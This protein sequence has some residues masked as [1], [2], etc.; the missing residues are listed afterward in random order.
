MS[1]T[2]PTAEALA[3]AL[4]PVRQALLG[5]ARIEADRLRTTAEQERERKL[6]TARQRANRIRAEARDRGQADADEA[7]ATDEAVAGRAG[8]HLILRARRDAYEHLRQAVEYRVAG[9]MAEP[10]VDAELRARVAGALGPGISLAAIP[11]GLAGT[12]GGRRVEIT[13][14][15]LTD[16]AL[17]ELGTS[18]EKLW[19]P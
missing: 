6:T 10:A 12:T 9:W 5:A 7:G 1:A 8:R 2:R 13:A 11:G 14:S 19:Q 16:E 4:A 15:A 3:D 18:A 17:Q